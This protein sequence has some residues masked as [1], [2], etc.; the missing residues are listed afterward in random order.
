MLEAFEA[1]DGQWLRL[2]A[3]TDADTSRVAPFDAIEIDAAGLL[4]MA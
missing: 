3:W 2:G 1:G 4:R